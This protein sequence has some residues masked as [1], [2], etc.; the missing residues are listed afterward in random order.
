MDNSK[1]KIM[2]ENGESIR[3]ILYLW[4]P[5]MIFATM[6][7]SLPPIIDS[8][9]IASLKSTTTYGALGM[10]NN[11][12]HSLLKFAEAI[13]VA[14]MAIIG[15]HNGAQDFKQCGRDLGDTFWT[16]VILGIAQFILIF[17]TASSIFKWL[18]VPEQMIQIGV[19]FLRLKSLGI[20]LTFISLGFFA[21]MKAIKNTRTPMAILMT[22]TGVFIIFDYILVH[23][24]LGFP[25]MGLTGS[26]VAT[27]IQYSIA[28]TIAIWYILSRAEYKKYFTKIF[29]SFF[30]VKQ[31]LRLLNLSWP[32]MIDKT[33]ISLSYVWLSKMI[34]PMGKY[35]IA[36]FDIIK[37]L[38]RF[39]LLPAVAFAQIIVFLV[40]NRIGAKDPVGAKSDIKKTMLLTSV[41][42]VSSLLF[43]CYNSHYF[44]GLF[45]PKNK[46]TNFASP[47][48][49]I[50]SVLVVFDFIQIILAGA[51]RGAGD[52]RTVM[53][54]RFFCCLL[55]F[56]PVAYLFSHMNIQN[57]I[58]KFALVY[59]SF[60]FTTGIIGLIYLLRIKTPNWQNKKI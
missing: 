47:V 45:D 53:W 31:A 30:N 59:G 52:V 56:A 25:K 1:F 35:A 21:F 42:V 13:P 9:I 55:F 49:I 58:Y 34:A 41:L 36:S 5:E 32:I 39:A 10:A 4:L 26:A 11:L 37:N 33:A 3:E 6:F 40:S 19:P 28:I 7:I 43:L 17:F 12:I 48:F 60:Y 46:F 44:I 24:K 29:I 38:E 57:P 50:I 20:L 54:T 14:T 8:Y 2:R 27:I 23:G 15:R 51:L 22:G 18:G 16:T